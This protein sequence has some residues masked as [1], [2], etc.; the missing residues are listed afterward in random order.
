MQRVEYFNQESKQAALAE[1]E[2]AGLV[3]VHT[4]T[5]VDGKSGY[6]DFETSEENAKRQRFQ[7]LRALRTTDAGMA[8]I[9]EDL[10]ALLVS[11][12]IIA[13]EELGQSAVQ[14]LAMRRAARLAL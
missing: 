11:K 13:E 10:I 3:H 8:R 6:M 9:G 12:G 14:K 2:A 1:Q 5:N 4:H 7:A